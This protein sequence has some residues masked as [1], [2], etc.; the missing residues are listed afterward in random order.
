MKNEATLYEK[1]YDE[2]F[3]KALEAYKATSES[4]E[5]EKKCQKAEE[6][7]KEKLSEEDYSLVIKETDIFVMNAEAEGRFLYKQGFKDC[8]NILKKFGVI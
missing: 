5:L 7:L 4:N 1:Y 6:K 2:L 3:E 8:I